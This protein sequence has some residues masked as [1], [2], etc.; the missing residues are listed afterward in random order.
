MELLDLVYNFTLTDYYQYINQPCTQEDKEILMVEL[1]NYMGHSNQLELEL[2]TFFDENNHIEQK[3]LLKFILSLTP[4]LTKQTLLA[5]SEGM[6]E[7]LLETIDTLQV[8][9][10]DL[11][12][13]ATTEKV[14]YLP[15]EYLIRKIAETENPMPYFDYLAKSIMLK[16]EAK[17]PSLDKSVPIYYRLDLEVTE[18]ELL[19]GCYIDT[20]V[21]F[22]TCLEPYIK[23]HPI[24][25][26]FGLSEL[27]ITV[28]DFEKLEK[29]GTF[30]YMQPMFECCL[31]SHTFMTT[32]FD[33]ARDT[34][35]KHYA[36][37][38]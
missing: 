22:D 11:I 15:P 18:K 25:I 7:F 6:S 34:I 17:Q 10:T 19:E 20:L 24:M 16:S 36:Q 27:D 21:L 26:H 32:D 29:S 2:F 38:A 31:G 9:I 30:S 12:T 4:Y 14:S 3:V 8:S 33:Y 5:F 35:S 37:I 1:K 23:E 13:W 28:Q